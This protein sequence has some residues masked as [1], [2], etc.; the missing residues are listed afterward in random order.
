MPFLTDILWKLNIQGHTK[1]RPFKSFVGGQHRFEGCH[2]GFWAVLPQTW[3]L[4]FFITSQKGWEPTTA[5]L[6]LATRFILGEKTTVTTFGSQ[7]TAAQPLHYPDFS[8]TVS[9]LSCPRNAQE[10]CKDMSPA[11]LETGNPQL[12]QNQGSYHVLLDCP[13]QS[14]QSC[15]SWGGRSGCWGLTGGAHCLLL[16]P[17]KQSSLMALRVAMVT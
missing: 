3:L 12:M 1:V 4:E 11:V 17:A 2:L 8:K 14:T 16:A 9:H 10:S 6:S 15:L 13:L 5:R 7:R